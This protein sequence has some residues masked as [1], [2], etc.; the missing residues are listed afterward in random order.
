MYRNKFNFDYK[1]G[2]ENE[3]K[4]LE[5]LNKDNINKFEKCK[6]NCEFDFFNDEY[7]LELKSR[8]NKYNQ[9]PTTMVGYNKILKAEQ[10]QSKKYKFLFLFTDGLYCYD[11]IKDDYEI[12]EGGRKEGRRGHQSGRKCTATCRGSKLRYS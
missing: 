6:K 4:V 8:S 12:K 5:Y 3:N 9:Y 2:I 11:F 1:K 10:D 7:Y